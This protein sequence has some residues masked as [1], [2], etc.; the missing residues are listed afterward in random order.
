MEIVR[1]PTLDAWADTV[2]AQLLARLAARPALR[3][4]LATGNTPVPVYDRCAAAVRA[5]TASFRDAEAFLLDEFGGVPRDAEGRC[6]QMLRRALIDHVDLPASRLHTIDTDA[7]E[8][9]AVCRGYDEAVGTLDLTILGIGMNGH[10]GMN[11][12]G[13]AADSLTR[14]VELAAETQ[15]SATHYFGGRATPTWGITIGMGT[16]LRSREIWLLATG[17]SKAA[18]LERMLAGPV[19]TELPA[20]LLREHPRSIL[21]CDEAAGA[22]I[23]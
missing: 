22:A 14:R 21:F 19:S 1:V 8:L 23:A 20:S 7:A 5:Q 11:E 2:A 3:L 9:D 16:V 17:A 12:P 6:E 18:I 10:I 4:C 13:S 15:Q